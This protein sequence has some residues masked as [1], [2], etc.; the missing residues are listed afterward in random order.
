M[1]EQFGH[2]GNGHHDKCSGWGEGR[3]QYGV[4][5]SCLGDHVVCLFLG[6]AGFF[7]CDDKHDSAGDNFAA[8]L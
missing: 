2:G 4:G 1:R 6:F 5:P 7:Y 8:L 3:I